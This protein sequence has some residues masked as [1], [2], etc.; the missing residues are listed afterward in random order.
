MVQFKNLSL[1]TF[2]KKISLTNYYEKKYL[3]N[4][5]KQNGGTQFIA[6]SNDTLTYFKKT[7]SQ[8]STHLLFNAIDFERFYR[9]LEQ[10][11]LNNKL[12]LINVGSFVAKKNQQFLIS[13]ANELKKQQIDFT[14]HFLGNGQIIKIVKLKVIENKLENDCHFHGNV[15]NVPEF[16]QSADVY[17]HSATDEPLG[18]VLLEAMAAG[19]PVVTLDGRGNRDLMEQ[20]RN[21]FML[22]EQN[23]ELFAQTIIE[24]WMDKKKY[25]QM[26]SYAQEY[27][28]Q[29]DIK[30]YV[31][32]LLELYEQI[33]LTL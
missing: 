31:E 8:Y 25:I 19:L 5:Y 27:A 1:L 26:A 6:I 16:L 2:L 28:K 9:P 10:K 15:N 20:G 17:V 22:Y 4:R 11:K 18:L 24:L 30:S 29:Y 13:V 12:R 21:G 23:A 7:A 32:K 33:R 14:L 3:F